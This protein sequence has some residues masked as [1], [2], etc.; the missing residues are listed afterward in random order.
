MNNTDTQTHTRASALTHSHSGIVHLVADERTEYGE[1]LLLYLPIHPGP[2]G[3]RDANQEIYEMQMESSHT[4]VLHS[5]SSPAPQR[6][7]EC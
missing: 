7:W 3:D 2:S 6:F 4:G 1:M 5:K